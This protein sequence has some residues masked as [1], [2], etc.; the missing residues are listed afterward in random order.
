[1]NK[2]EVFK[3]KVGNYLNK[4][5]IDYYIGINSKVK[6]RIIYLNIHGITIIKRIHEK[7]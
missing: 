6:S 3:N 4:D 1:M 7:N 5:Y 2:V